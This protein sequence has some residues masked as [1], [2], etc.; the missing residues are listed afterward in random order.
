MTATSAAMSEMTAPAVEQHAELAEPG[1]KPPGLDTRHIPQR[2][3]EEARDQQGERRNRRNE[4]RGEAGERAQH[5][6]GELQP[7]AARV[8]GADGRSPA[9][10]AE[11]GQDDRAIAD[12][13][14]EARARAS[15]PASGTH[16]AAAPA[17]KGMSPARPRA[18]AAPGMEVET[19][20]SVMPRNLACRAAKDKRA[21]S[22]RPWRASRPA[23]RASS[24]PSPRGRTAA[25]TG[26]APR[27][28]G[29]PACRPACRR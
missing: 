14:L 11:E 22:A 7:L 6:G 5:A 1:R 18:S 21:G 15:G 4:D 24:R 8:I 29:C 27:R 23:P 2:L 3:H 17:A 9:D 13:E 10:A 12:D 19:F 20:C 28:C 25:G 26:G 16:S